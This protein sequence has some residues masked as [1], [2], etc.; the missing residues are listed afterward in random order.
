MGNSYWIVIAAAI[1][2]IFCFIFSFGLWALRKRITHQELQKHHDVAGFLLSTIGVLYSVILG[3][4]VINA[5]ERYDMAAGTVHTEAKMLIDLYRAAQFFPENE[6][7][8]IRTALRGYIEYVLTEDWNNYKDHVKAS[9]AITKLWEGFENVELTGE[10]TKIWYSES[11]QKLDDLLN[12][13]L[14]RQFFDYF[15]K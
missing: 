1:A 9:R 4:T 6:R 3:F 8:T 13:R 2:F 10:R 15:L 11:I 5:K 12:A 7:N 14:E